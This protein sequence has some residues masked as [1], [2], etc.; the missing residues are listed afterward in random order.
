MPAGNSA[1]SVR[2]VVLVRLTFCGA[3]RE[4]GRSAIL[5]ET[6]KRLMLDY[7]VKLGSRSEYP[8]PLQGSIDAY[9]LS[10]AHLDHCGSSPMLYET[11][12][13]P[14]FTTYPTEALSSLLIKDSMKI[15][16]LRG[17]H[18]P[19][20]SFS[21]KKY[22]SAFIPLGY[23][24]PFQLSSDVRVTLLDAG[25][26]PGSAMVEVYAEHKR[27][28]YTGDFK[29]EPTR[30]HAGA[31]LEEKVD[32]LVMESTYSD[33]DHPER[34][35][36][37]KQLVKEIRE[38]IEQGGI[39]LLPSFAVGRSQE[40][41]I[42]LSELLPDADVWLDGMS[43]TATQ[44]ISDYPSYIRD[45][46]ALRKAMRNADWVETEAERRKATAKPGVIVSSAGMLD[47]GPAISYL[48]RLN[49]R[50]KIILTGYQIEGTNARTLIETSTVEVDGIPT[51][52]KLPVKYL[53]MSAHAGR[54][55]L[56]K[57][58]KKANPEKIFCIHGDACEAFAQELCGMGYE[59]YAPAMGKTF[60]V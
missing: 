60:E 35:Q 50:S 44:L 52:I 30:L 58:V 43:K 45:A 17:E 49:E 3:A 57:L 55:D 46:N 10:H 15:S 37:E 54:S 20:S 5:L 8:M 38:T 6:G 28:L 36:L 39:A 26:I 40:L 21:L 33:E 13:V 1:S 47:G 56:L 19:F 11:A 31:D 22:E 29:L 16:R 27:V 14:C 51:K 7:G 12:N 48:L 9:I 25:H 2:A 4:V 23:R 32:I 41:L 42:V 53:D 24:K 34:K 59:A 18:V